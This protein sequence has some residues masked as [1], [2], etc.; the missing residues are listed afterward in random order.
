MARVILSI[1][2]LLDFPFET[3]FR[4]RGFASTSPP[5]NRA[6]TV[7]SLMILVNIFPRLAS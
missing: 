3:A 6:A 1:G 2:R 5:P 7:I 4:N